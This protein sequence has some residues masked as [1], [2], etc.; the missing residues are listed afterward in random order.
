MLAK[1]PAKLSRPPGSKRASLLKQRK[2]QDAFEQAARATTLDATSARARSLLGRNAAGGFRRQLPAFPLNNFAPRLFF[3][4]SEAL[5]IARAGDDRLL[6]KPIADRASS[7]LR[8]AVF[9]DP[10]SRPDYIFSLAQAAAR[11]EALQRG[12]RCI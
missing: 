6:R 8:R 7:G 11:C 3:D 12:G 10:G 9:L 2:I 4:Q 5:A 1:R